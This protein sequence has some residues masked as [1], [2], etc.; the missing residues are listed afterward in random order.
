MAT[1]SVA[2]LSKQLSSLTKTASTAAAAAKTQGKDTTGITNAINK[3]NAMVAQTNRQGSKSFSGSAEEKAYNA[4]VITPSSIAPA[5]GVN[6]PT[7]PTVTAPD[8]GATNT[9]LATGGITTDAT[10]KLTVQPTET[11]TGTNKYQ[12]LSDIFNSYLQESQKNTP[13][14]NEAIYNAQYKADKIAEKQQAVN[15]ITAQINTIVAN[16]DANVLRVTGQGRGIP[17]AIIGGQQA[18]INKEAAIAALPLQAQLA[19]AQGNLSLAQS[20]LD[21]MFQIKSKDAQA[22]Y[23][24]KTKLLDSVFNFAT[25]IEQNKLE[26]LKVEESRKYTEKQDFIKAQNAALSNALAQ[27]APA[28][29]YNAIKNA[30]DVAG[31]TIAAGIYNGDVLAQQIKKKQLADLYA[32]KAASAPEIKNFGTTDAPMWKQYNSVSNSWQDVSGL[33]NSSSP[34][35]E[36]IKKT[37]SQLDF[38]LDTVKNAKKYSG[39][40]GAGNT[41]WE[42]IK[43]KFAGSTDYTNLVAQA[44]TLKTNMLTLATDPNIKKFFGPNMSNNDVQLMSSAGTTLNPEMQSPEELKKEVI[45]VQDFVERAKLSL[46]G[47]TEFGKTDGGIR[48][49]N[50]PDGTI[51]D[52]YG[53]KYDANGNPL[54]KKN[55][56]TNE[57]FF[58]SFLNV[59]GL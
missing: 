23:D 50:L 7:K 52:A 41:Y 19:A 1:S 57:G 49:A 26:D 45:R 39:S 32:P 48:V 13:V 34:S 25:K 31:V 8:I 9:G 27:G 20:H 29:V 14:S 40:S 46:N 4:N 6:L 38:L 44:N 42:G 35:P 17:E 15:D 54:D 55:T 59:F 47:A 43:Q 21:T 2:S 16:R 18:E 12:G 22:Q 56:T 5:A 28:S 33:N 58:N 10:G 24:Y 37:S 30:T 53:N 3:S 51:Q 36:A 11:T